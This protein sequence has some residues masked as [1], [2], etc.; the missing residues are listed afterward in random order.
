MNRIIL[1]SMFIFVFSACK[2]EMVEKPK[3]LIDKKTMTNILYDLAVLDALKSNQAPLLEQ[4][5]INLSTYIYQKYAIDSL[6]LVENNKYYA[7]DIKS[8]KKMY[9]EVEKRLEEETVL[10][11]SLMKKTTQTIDLPKTQKDTNKLERK[12]RSQKV[13][14]FL[15]KT[16]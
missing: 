2:D 12:K 14:R 8:Y 7:A 4:K 13:N 5:N 3:K 1:F 16:N 11:D 6:Q 9:E 10:N 15:N